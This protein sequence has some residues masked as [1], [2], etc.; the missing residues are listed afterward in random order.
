[1]QSFGSRLRGEEG[2]STWFF[3]V[4]LIC[5]KDLI[6]FIVIG[7]AVRLIYIFILIIGD[8]F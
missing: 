1:M 2:S 8:I 4:I 5:C 6:R 3:R 7:I